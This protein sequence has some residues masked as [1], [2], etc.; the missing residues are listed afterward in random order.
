VICPQIPSLM[1]GGIWGQITGG[2]PGANPVRID[3][4]RSDDTNLPQG[5][6]QRQTAPHRGASGETLARP[7]G[8]RSNR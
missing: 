4:V 1:G 7:C 5:R 2:L 8:M 3:T 6:R